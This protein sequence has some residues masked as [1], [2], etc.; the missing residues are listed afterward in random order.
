MTPATTLTPRGNRAL[1]T[2]AS[3]HPFAP[4]QVAIVGGGLAGLAAATRLAELSV[5][6]SVFDMGTRVLGGRSC[7]RVLS[8]ESGGL[9][10]DH[11]AQFIAPTSEEFTE[12][13][14]RWVKAGVAAPWQG[15]FGAL[16]PRTFVFTSSDELSGSNKVMGAGFCGLFGHLG[17]KSELEKGNQSVFVGTPTMGSISQFLASEAKAQGSSIKLGHKVRGYLFIHPCAIC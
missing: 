15:R 11:G 6:S 10:F 2:S 4:A 1:S 17:G 8:E 9:A 16:D 3:H 13:V 7:S 5:H 12:E 14:Q